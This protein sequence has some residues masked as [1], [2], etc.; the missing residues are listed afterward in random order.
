MTMYWALYVTPLLSGLAP[1]R[2]DAVSRRVMVGVLALFLIT[3]IG[4]RDWVG[5]DW[6][7]Y[8]EQ[9][10][11]LQYE[12]LADAL[13][14][15]DVAYQL[16]NWIFLRS[17]LDIH[18][19]NTA[20]AVVF[21]V[22]LL[23][24]CARQPIPW[25]ALTASMTFMVTVVSMGYTRQATAIGFL[26]LAFNAFQDSRLVRF[27]VLVGLATAF[28]KTA[29]VF[30]L[31]AVFL[32]AGR[33]IGPVLI[34]FGATI[35]IASFTLLDHLDFLLYGYVET[36]MESDGGIFRIAMNLFAVAVFLVF[37]RRWKDMYQDYSL[38]LGLSVVIVLSAPVVIYAPAAADRMHLYFLPYQIAVLSRVPVFLGSSMLRLPATV[39]IAGGYGL[40]LYVWLQ[41]ATHAN[42]WIPYSSVLFF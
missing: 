32:R 19:S 1:F 21:V 11:A 40:S 10:W 12:P 35:F 24:F 33:H 28:H 27:I 39:G 16:I 31:M 6:A 15:G 4:T 26:M 38:Y 36:S 2:L 30:G 34:G 37:R 22:G 9:Y 41:Y 23:A 17:G 7:T 3:V 5:C 14:K 8:E 29:I 20:C 42:C 25:L 13:A 18:W